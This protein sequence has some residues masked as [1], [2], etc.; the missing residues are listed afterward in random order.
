MK[1][2]KE[3]HQ[4]TQLKVLS[5]KLLRHIKGGEIKDRIRQNPEV[6]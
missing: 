3:I 6:Q 2:L 1:T 4:Q 5:T